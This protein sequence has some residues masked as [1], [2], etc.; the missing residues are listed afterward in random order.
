MCI[1]MELMDT[2]IVRFYQTMHLLDEVSLDQ[3][4]TFVR[5]VAHDVSLLERIHSCSYFS[6]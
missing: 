6:L 2:S 4:N 1:C 5:R 3:L